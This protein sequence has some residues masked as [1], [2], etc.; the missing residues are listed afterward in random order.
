VGNGRN[1][2]QRVSRKG[3]EVPEKLTGK[4]FRSGVLANVK[5]DLV[6][7]RVSWTDQKDLFLKGMGTKRGGSL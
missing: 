7:Q 6:A 1:W 5:V 2:S 3:E 4:K